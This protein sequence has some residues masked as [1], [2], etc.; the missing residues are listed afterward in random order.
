MCFGLF[1]NIGRDRSS[2]SLS[3]CLFQTTSALLILN[4]ISSLVSSF[5]TTLESF[6][7]LLFIAHFLLVFFQYSYKESLIVHIFKQ[8]DYVMQVQIRPDR[9]HHKLSYLVCL[10]Y[11]HKIEK[12]WEWS[13]GINFLKPSNSSSI[14]KNNEA[15]SYPSDANDY[16]RP[17]RYHCKFII[18]IVWFG[19]M[20][21]WC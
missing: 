5:M 6:K 21:C 13:V 19:I 9:R 4:R 3:V 10:W 18:E 1:V 16:V 7:H 14:T 17:S 12:D 20:I 11:F 15:C 8:L 2:P